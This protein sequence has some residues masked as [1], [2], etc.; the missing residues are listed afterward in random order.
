VPVTA[1]HKDSNSETAS[2]TD[3]INIKIRSNAPI[4]QS[5]HRE[6]EK[7]SEDDASAIDESDDDDDD[8]AY[9]IGAMALDELEN[10]EDRSNSDT[11]AFDTTWTYDNECIMTWN[12]NNE[13]IMRSDLI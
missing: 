8:A 9:N 7:A 5:A 12:L 3:N 6:K 4:Q 13:Y 11:S 1:T 10:S 2:E